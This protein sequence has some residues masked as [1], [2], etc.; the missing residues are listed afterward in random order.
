VYQFQ[1]FFL[2][3]YLINCFCQSKKKIYPQ[4]GRFFFK[5]IASQR[6]FPPFPGNLKSCRKYFG[7]FSEDFSE[8]VFLFLSQKIRTVPLLIKSSAQVK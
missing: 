2:S 3:S 4:L 8:S 5:P 6:Y 1:I 7:K